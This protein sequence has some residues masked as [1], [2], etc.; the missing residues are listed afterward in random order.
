MQVVNM[1]DA[2]IGYLYR[3]TMQLDLYSAKGTS[4]ELL[5]TGNVKF[6][7]LLVEERLGAN[8]KHASVVQ[9]RSVSAP[10]VV[11]AEVIFERERTH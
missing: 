4:Y 10:E 9:L 8:R 11:L 2:F 1:D 6:R 5:A 7:N 3:G